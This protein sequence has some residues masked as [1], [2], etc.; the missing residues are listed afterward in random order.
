MAQEITERLIEFDPE[1]P[2]KY[3]FAMIRMGMF[4]KNGAYH[5]STKS[6]PSL[7]NG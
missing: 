6:M 1:C 7:P 3:D 5:T 4:S 2:V